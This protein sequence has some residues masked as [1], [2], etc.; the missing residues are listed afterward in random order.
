MLEQEHIL[1]LLKITCSTAPKQGG[2]GNSAALTPVRN[3]CSPWLSRSAGDPRCLPGSAGHTCSPKNH[4]QQ[5][6]S[7]EAQFP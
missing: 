2:G 5:S 1:F 7:S 6:K 4:A 3:Q